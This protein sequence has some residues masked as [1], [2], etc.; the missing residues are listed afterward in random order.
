[1]RNRKKKKNKKVGLSRNKTVCMT[2][3]EKTP[4][5]AKKESGNSK[6][7][8]ATFGKFGADVLKSSA[9]SMVV[10]ILRWLFRVLL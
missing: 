4:D 10:E 2:V 6:S 5:S 3:I 7:V 8:M 1:M 9:G